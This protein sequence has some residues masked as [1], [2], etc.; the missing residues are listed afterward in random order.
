[1]KAALLLA[2]GDL[3]VEET[4]QPKCPPGG[5]IVRVDACSICGTDV[6]MWR[7]GHRDLTYPRVLG[8]EFVGTVVEIDG[9]Q[10]AL[11]IGDRVQVW[12]GIACGSCD[13]CK[14]GRDNLCERVGIIGF[15]VDGGFAEMVALPERSL[16]HGGINPLPIDLDPFRGTLAEPLACCISGQDA[17]NVGPDDDILI[18]GGGPMGLLHAK[19]ARRR[20]VG[21]ISI[22]E[23]DAKRADFSSLVRPDR[24]IAGSLEEGVMD[25][26]DGKGVDVI[27]V[28]APEVRVDEGLLNLLAPGG[29]LNLFSGMGESISKENIDLNRIHY[30]EISI[31]G[32]YGC[33]SEGCRQALEMLSDREFDCEWI[34][35]KKV[36]LDRIEEG[37]KHSL[38]RE[39]LKAV[40]TML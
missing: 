32:S 38:M 33:R 19:L 21:S 4:N 20:G 24:L 31:M 35:T 27:I 23:T 11:E 28:C 13:P 40:V 17:C 15:N 2:P 14:R 8:H 18:I 1:M 5:L 6:K 36:S 7:V 25:F 37:L 10:K 30:R 12:P 29:R 3:V 26:T 39:G 22:A 9:E 34:F 16:K